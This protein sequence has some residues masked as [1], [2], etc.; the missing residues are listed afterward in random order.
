MH[1][2]DRARG[3]HPQPV[4]DQ[5]GGG[6]RWLRLRDT[7]VTVDRGNQAQQPLTI[8]LVLPPEV[9]Q[10]LRLP[11]PAHPAVVRQLH[12]PDHRVVPVLLLRRP[13]VHAHQPIR[14]QHRDQAGHG[15]SFAHAF[16]RILA[17]R[18][19]ATSTDTNQKALHAH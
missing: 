13:Q 17:T 9:E 4:P 14:N 16:P 6:S 19:P 15:K 18:D 5:L 2:A 10:Y 8:E 12:I 7:E 1:R 3:G 11:H